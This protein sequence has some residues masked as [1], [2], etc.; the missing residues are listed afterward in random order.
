M[1]EPATASALLPSSIVAHLGARVASS[2]LV[3]DRRGSAVW[4]VGLDDGTQ[5]AVK[6]ARDNPEPSG[7]KRGA[8]LLAAR[9]AAVLRIIRPSIPDYLHAYGKA[10]DASWI[11]VRWIDAPSLATCWREARGG[12]S[13][14]GR[15][16]AGSAAA[17]AAAAVADL[18]ANGWR[19]ADLQPT[20]IRC[21]DARAHLIDYALSQGP[22]DQPVTPDVPYRGGIL[23]LVAP[24][25]AAELLDT[26][27][28]IG[29]PITEPAEV[30]TLAATLMACWTGR[31]MYRY[32][33]GSPQTSPLRNI[34]AAVA[35]SNRPA[36]TEMRPWSWPSMEGA[37]TVALDPH[38][39]NRPTASQL[40][41]AFA[42]CS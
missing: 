28:G 40:R 34:L 6:A 12:S 38:A 5:L 2:T 22:P 36:V 21:D 25:V 7:V 3:G 26:D 42:C 29:I 35:N 8:R 41:D 13:H 20:H 31:W 16:R 18:H 11:A 33:S 17:L 24:E 10:D 32:N 4:R 19:H 1:T 23:H 9:E 15:R 37:L 27:D 39:A 14:S 30:F